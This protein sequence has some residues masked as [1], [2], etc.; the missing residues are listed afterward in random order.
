MKAINGKA[1]IKAFGLIIFELLAY[2]LSFLIFFIFQDT[3]EEETICFI[4]TGC[5]I[6]INF[7]AFA[8]L[9]P[10]ISLDKST[11]KILLIFYSVLF[12]I[13]SVLYVA[14]STGLIAVYWIT[15]FLNRSSY[16]LNCAISDIFADNQ[17]VPAILGIIINF[18][19]N[20]ANYYIYRIVRR[21]RMKNN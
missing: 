16:G 4:I 15:W 10:L 14:E 5:M 13:G 7:L 20:F 8:I 6:V 11:E 19:F 17:V 3:F 18:I 2:L 12:I 9:L 1:V 21:I